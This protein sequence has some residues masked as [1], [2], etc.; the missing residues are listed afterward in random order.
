[1]ILAQL[2]AE[3][4]A[5]LPRTVSRAAIWAIPSTVPKRS[6]AASIKAMHW[7][8]SGTS[9]ATARICTPAR[10]ERLRV[11]RQGVGIASSDDDFCAI[12]QSY[13]GDLSAEACA[14]TADHDRHFLN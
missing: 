1:M 3:V 8:S 4:E 7:T 14:H 10:V 2:L 11:L 13:R 9:V 6:V 5:R 12:A